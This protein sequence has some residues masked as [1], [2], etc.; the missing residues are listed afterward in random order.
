MTIAACLG[1]KDE[2][3][4]IGPAIAHLRRIGVS[5]IFASDAGSSDGT[6]TILAKMARS[7][8]LDH[9]PFDDRSLDAAGEEALTRDIMD[10][11]RRRGADWLI[12]VDADEFPLPRGGRLDLLPAL[13][14]ADVL[15]VPRY[16]VVV[17]AGGAAM[18][19]PDPFAAPGAILLHTPAENRHAVTTRLRADPEAAWVMGLPAPKV[20]LRPDR[21]PGTAEGHHDAGTEHGLRREPA[22]GLFIAH[23]PF[24]TEARFARKIDNIRAL[25]AASGAEWGPDSAWH[26]R[27]WLDNVDRRGGVAGEMARNLVTE[28]QLAELRAAGLVSAAPELW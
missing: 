18:P 21:V 15:V 19:L 28:A 8:D 17:R 25:V 12:F 20:M 26:W 27:R 9:L 4:L 5:H 24:T 3:D 13:A 11:A 23:L 7:S 2:V 6:E 16:N 14:R 10:R 1:V 22:E